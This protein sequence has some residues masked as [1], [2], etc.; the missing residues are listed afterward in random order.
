MTKEDIQKGNIVY[1]TRILPGV[2][3]YD[4]CELKIRT[5]EET[6]FCGSDKHD[7]HAYLF[8]LLS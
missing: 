3:I 7:K 5:V 1:Y 4:L 2:G 8:G 6:Y